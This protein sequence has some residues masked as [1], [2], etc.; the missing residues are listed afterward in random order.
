MVFC[1][2]CDSSYTL[3]EFIRAL[4]VIDIRATM[5]IITIRVTFPVSRS[6]LAGVTALAF[7]IDL[8][9]PEGWVLLLPRFHTN[10]QSKQSVFCSSVQTVTSTGGCSPFMIKS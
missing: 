1:D 10:K 5:G 3:L 2:L 7:S 4:D 9:R 8:V 6:V